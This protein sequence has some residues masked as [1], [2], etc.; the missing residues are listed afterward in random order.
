[1]SKMCQGKSCLK[2]I[3][4]TGFLLGGSIRHSNDEKN[5]DYRV[6]WARARHR[7]GPQKNFTGASEDFLRT[8]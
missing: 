2:H 5:I 7:L 8:W 3:T 1:M 4:L 6:W